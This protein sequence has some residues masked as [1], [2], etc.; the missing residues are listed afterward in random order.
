MKRKEGGKGPDSTDE[1]K[2]YEKSA[3][4]NLLRHD[5]WPWKL[6]LP[7]ICGIDMD[8]SGRSDAWGGLMLADPESERIFGVSFADVALL[9]E[10]PIYQLP[11]HRGTE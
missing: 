4:S 6:A 5:T 7:L 11:P 9:S 8:N 1:W 3:L 10:D 2:W